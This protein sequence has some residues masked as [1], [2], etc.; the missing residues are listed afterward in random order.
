MEKRSPSPIFTV[1][2]T[3]QPEVPLKHTTPILGFVLWFLGLAAL[4]TAALVVHSHPQPWT[5]ELAF[6]QTIQAWSL[7]AWVA[8][9]FKT[10]TTINDPIPSGIAAAILIVFMLIKRWIRPAL[11]LGYI[12]LVANSIDALIGD[13]VARPR[14]DPHVIHVN[15]VL[16]FNSFPSGHTEHVVIFYGFLLFLSLMK[17]VREWKHKRW[18]IPLQVL[19]A[20]DILIIGFARVFEGEHWVSD[21]L[22]GYLSGILWLTLFIYLY[23]RQWTRNKPGAW[24]EGKAAAKNR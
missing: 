17:P 14:P 6:S 23:S 15:S 18:L 9:T 5:F 13:A 2:Q 22:G 16:S 11:F 1:P 3:S 7:P 12:V 10:I 19:M 21:V 24:Q 8:T 20:F 4:S